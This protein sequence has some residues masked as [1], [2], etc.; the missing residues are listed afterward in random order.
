MIPLLL[1]AA[2][3]T[4]FDHGYLVERL[5]A[6]AAHGAVSRVVGGL[7]DKVVRFEITTSDDNEGSDSDAR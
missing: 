3:A 7:A 4:S 5:A 6:R 1:S 2:L